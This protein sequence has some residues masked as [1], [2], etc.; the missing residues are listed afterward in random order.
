MPDIV[1]PSSHCIDLRYIDT[2]DMAGRLGTELR[3]GVWRVQCPDQRVRVLLD[4]PKGP[5]VEIFLFSIS[6]HGRPYYDLCRPLF[7]IVLQLQN[8]M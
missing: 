1:H 4:M 2:E 3:T 7:D 8:Y 5:R 6:R